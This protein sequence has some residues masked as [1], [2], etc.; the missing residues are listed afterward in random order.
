M[1]NYKGLAY[2]V[3][4]ELSSKVLSVTELEPRFEGRRS[5]YKKAHVITLVNG[6]HLLRSYNTIVAMVTSDGRYIKDGNY[7]ATTGRHQ[8]EFYNQFA[9]KGSDAIHNNV[10][11]NMQKVLQQTTP[12]YYKLFS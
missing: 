4:N 9:T 8:H 1:K 12:Q 6:A 10:T 11:Y 2:N 3:Y 5:Y 7:S